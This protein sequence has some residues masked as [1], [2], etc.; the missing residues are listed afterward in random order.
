MPSSASSLSPP[1]LSGGKTDGRKKAAETDDEKGEVAARRQLSA[2]RDRPSE[3]K[4]GWICARIP[5]LS[6]CPTSS[7]VPPSFAQSHLDRSPR[8]R[9]LSRETRKQPP[10]PLRSTKSTR[11]SL[12]Q[13]LGREILHVHGFVKFVPVVAYHSCLSLPATFWQPRKS[14]IS[15]PS[16]RLYA[17]SLCCELLRRLFAVGDVKEAVGGKKVKGA[18][19]PRT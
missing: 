6:L 12:K 18:S 2:T 1:P 4:D 13:L 16:T 19:G 11:A 15:L 8:C 17:P 10:L 14:I 3:E 9:P 5:S 7:L